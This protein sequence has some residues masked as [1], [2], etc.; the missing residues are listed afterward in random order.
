MLLGGLLH[1]NFDIIG[2]SDSSASNSVKLWLE[3]SIGS[4]HFLCEMLLIINVEPVGIKDH[5]HC[6]LLGGLTTALS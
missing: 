4:I 1:L 3:R 6:V 5:S 2:Y